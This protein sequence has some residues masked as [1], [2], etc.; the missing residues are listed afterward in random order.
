MTPEYAAF[1][2]NKMP[3]PLAAG[4]AP[5]PMPSHLFDYQADATAFCVR[6]GRAALFLDTG[7]G[8]TVCE[9]EFARQGGGATNE[10]SLILTPLA[11]AR[12]IEAEAIRFGYVARVIREQ[13]DVLPGINICNY[14][15]L[16]K[17]DT[18]AFGAVV[19]DES[20][21]LK[22]FMGA[23]TRSLIDAFAATPFR[24]CATATPAPNDH[25]ELGTHAEFLGIM[26]RADMLQR[27]FINDGSRSNAWRLKGHAW[28]SFWD[29]MASWARMAETP[30]DLGYDASRFM[31]PPMRI[32]RH[33]AAGDT[34]APAGSLFVQDVSATNIHDIKRQTADAR[35]E[36]VAM[37]VKKEPTRWVIWADTDYEADALMRNL[38]DA[39]EVRGS[40]PTEL[41]EMNLAAF[42]SGEARIIVTKPSVAGLGLNWQHCCR[43]AFVG[44][45]FSYEAWY[46]A[47]RRCWRYGQR[48]P[49]E[50]H[51]IVAEGE[52]QIGR[53]IDRKAEDH[54]LMKR[55][56]AD[57]MRRNRGQAS[58]QR[59]PYNPTHEGKLPTWLSAA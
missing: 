17:L 51:L 31:L 12:Q 21:I 34:R 4:I 56:M 10:T 22:S 49:V 50:V 35:A 45:S 27:W 20:S 55:A 53:V 28:R 54:V 30:A 26:T 25:A 24:L 42:A 39:I 2:A 48:Y 16:D 41:K 58:E 9:L 59:V 13:A 23:T 19:L 46:Q 14:D 44:R 7:L 11:V 57:A 38:D 47:V 33:R 1:L 52:D 43:M 18:H 32:V 6:H 15:R 5:G 8:K 40:H 29:W 36:A 37:A 3:I